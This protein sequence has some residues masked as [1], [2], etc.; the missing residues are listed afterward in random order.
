MFYPLI[1]TWVRFALRIF[2][3]DVAITNPHAL[4]TAG[5]VLLTCNHPNSF[6]DAIIIGA[7]YKHP[8]HFL[9]RGDAFSK[10]WHAR[11]LHLL[12]MIPVYRLSEG[13]ENLVLNEEAFRKSKEVL[14]AHGVL[15]IFIE[16]ICV[17][18]HELQPFK[19]G[20]ARIAID[21]KE[22]PGMKVLPMAMAYNSFDRFGKTININ[23]GNAIPVK[24]LLPF[25]EENKN[26][27][28]MN[29][30]L[31]T[32]IESRVQ[33][34]T[35][36][37]ATIRDRNILARLAALI[38]T[39]IHWPLYKILSRSIA[40]K[41]QGTVFYDSVLFGALLFVYPV[42]LLL[43]MIVLL[44]LSVPAKL[45]PIILLLHPITARYAVQYR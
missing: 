27:R 21:C 41:T 8:I 29:G 15:L 7:A 31:F 9:A 35:T 42:Y 19:K 36:I 28:Y 16:G 12:Q 4:E 22:I 23:C 5:P 17:H 44:M 11:L 3:R 37:P 26:M 33:I 2:L 10:P 1:K 20:A 40:K 30:L 18:K 43:L 34:P 45:L 25:E 14:S 6:L 38:G 13:K 24:E 32:E 39:I